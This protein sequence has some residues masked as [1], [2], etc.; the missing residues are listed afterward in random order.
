M[1][2][3]RGLLCRTV[4]SPLLTQTPPPPPPFVIIQPL[5]MH[6]ACVNLHLSMPEALAASTINA[7]AALGMSESYGSLEVGKIG[8]MVVLN[9][10]R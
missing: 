8:D 6:L 9:T 3:Y 7:A 4:L 2:E 1:C 5:V 10:P